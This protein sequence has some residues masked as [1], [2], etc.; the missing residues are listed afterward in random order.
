MCEIISFEIAQKLKEKGFREKCF[1]YYSSYSETLYYNTIKNVVPS[2]VLSI[3]DFGKCYNCFEANNIDA[4]TISQVLKWLREEKKWSIVIRLYGK[5]GWYWFVQDNNGELR[6]SQLA[7][8]DE[9]F[10]T[11]E[12]AAL[13]GIEYV[14]DNLI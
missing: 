6:A 7:S 10:S 4:P 9:C 1:A 8:C 14:L 5:N 11:Y 13:A 3:D 2:R 12:Q